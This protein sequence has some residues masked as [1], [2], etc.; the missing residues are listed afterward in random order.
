VVTDGEDP[1]KPPKTGTSPSPEREKPS[2]KERWLS[3]SFQVLPNT[4]IFSTTGDK[5][6]SPGDITDPG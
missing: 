1:Y 2:I 4:V 3:S 6:W 5:R